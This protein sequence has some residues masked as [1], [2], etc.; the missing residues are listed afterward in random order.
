MADIVLNVEVRDRTGTGGARAA[1]RENMVPGIL[2]GGQAAPVPIAVRMNEFRKALYT[3]K[4]TGHLVTLKY[5][6]ES[7]PVIAKDVQFHP[8]SD[9][10][11]HFDLF[12]VDADQEIKIAVPVHFRN[13]EACPAFRKGGSLEIV[14]HEVEVLAKANNI[15]EELVVDLTG[16]Q[17][18]DT[19]RISDIQLPQG[20]QPT[21]S[22]RDFV[23]A[24]L[25]IS[26]AAISEDQAAAADE[27]AAP[28]EVPAGDEAAEGA[29]GAEAGSAES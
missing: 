14:R 12:R 27:A 16:R 25:K 13:E 29:E 22:D 26:S 4:L 11:V 5:G 8:V 3:G 2:Y 7:Q 20:V 6:D 24:S 17:L 23:I 19:I 9:Q 21:L 15:P 18:G 1:R 10:P 28:D